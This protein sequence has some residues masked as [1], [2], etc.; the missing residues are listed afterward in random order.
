MNHVLHNMYK[1]GFIKDED[2]AHFITM[3]NQ[4]EF[5]IR[6]E[7]TQLWCTDASFKY[8]CI[9]EIYNKITDNL[10]VSLTCTE[11]D[12]MNIL[13]CYTQMNDFGS[14]D[15][16][17]PPL[18]PYNASGNFYIIR[19]ETYRIDSTNVMSDLSNRWFDV[20][21]YN[22]LLGYPVPIISV[23]LDLSEIEELMDIIYFV[24]LI[25][26]ESENALMIPDQSPSEYT[27]YGV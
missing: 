24:F 9:I 6:R 7:Q 15:I 17:V 1:M 14:Q 27:R 16:F 13:D 20:L 12:I 18:K 22:P 25:D 2:M 23:Q 26:I 19:M 21:E 8:K 4:Y 10:L 5:I 3:D 11:E